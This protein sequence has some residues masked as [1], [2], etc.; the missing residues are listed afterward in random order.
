[1]KRISKTDKII[2]YYLSKVDWIV[3]PMRLM[4]IIK[5]A[6]L[7]NQKVEGEP[8]NLEWSDRGLERRSPSISNS[9]DSLEKINVIEKTGKGVKLT[10][11][12]PITIDADQ[13]HS[14][15]L[16]IRKYQKLPYE[17]I[18]QVIQGLE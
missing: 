2:I 7:L 15:D 14:I 10:S 8:M 16:A 5:I 18:R 12:F 17:C 11:N 1:M 4:Q 6:E 3:T 9:I 13:A